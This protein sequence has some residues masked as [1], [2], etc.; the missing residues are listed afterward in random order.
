MFVTSPQEFHGNN[1]DDN[2]REQKEP[3][4][5]RI[6]DEAARNEIAKL[7]NVLEVSP[8]I[9]VMTDIRYKDKSYPAFMGAL[10]PSA[11]GGDAFDTMQGQFFPVADG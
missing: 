2:N 10:P 8:E 7:P 11:K 4:P 5:N 9:R 6:V 1:N 3:E